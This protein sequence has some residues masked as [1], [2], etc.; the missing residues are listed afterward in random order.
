[1]GINRN[2]FH[3]EVARKLVSGFVAGYNSF[4]VEGAENIPKEGPVLL[5]S[6]HQSYKDI[7]VQGRVLGGHVGR[8]GNWVM[9]SS[10]PKYFEKLGGLRIVRSQDIKKSLE[11]LDSGEVRRM[12]RASIKEAQKYKRE[13]KDAMSEVYKQGELLVL[14]P[15]RTRYPYKIGTISMPLINYTKQLQLEIGEEIPLI[16]M[17]MS[18]AG[19]KIPF[20]DKMFPAHWI[21]RTK[22]DVKISRLD[23]DQDNLEDAISSEMARL[24]GNLRA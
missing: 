8:P 20:T 11:G 10:L 18:Y 3:Y 24:S 13:L 21:P 19:F 6:K 9:K 23:W 16:I 14:H 2:K 7:M 22:I 12:K 17:G 5:L 1:M 4:N 15:E